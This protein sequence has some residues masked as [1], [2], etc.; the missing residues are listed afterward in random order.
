MGSINYGSNDYV[1]LGLNLDLYNCSD[2][3]EREIN[4]V[5]QTIE[6]LIDDAYFTNDIS[7]KIKC[8][9]Y[10]GFYIDIDIWLPDTYEDLD[11]QDTYMED[12]ITAKDLLLKLAN[13][14][15][16]CY[17]PGWC[18]GYYNQDDT[19]IKIIECIDKLINKHNGIM[20]DA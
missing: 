10:E 3:D 19:K 14:G 15:L 2:W 11:E 20:I 18:I 9:H 16:V 6:D 1:N 8:G 4:D 7:F 5:M 13:A 12:L 17:S